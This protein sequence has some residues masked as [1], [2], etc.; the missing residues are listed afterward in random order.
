MTA[1][2]ALMQLNSVPPLY[3][4]SKYHAAHLHAAVLLCV[5]CIRHRSDFGA[6]VLCDPRYS[7]STETTASLSKW[8]RSSVRQC[9]SVEVSLPLVEAFFRQH[10]PQEDRRHAVQPEASACADSTLAGGNGDAGCCAG[11]SGGT[12]DCGEGRGGLEYKPE[13]AAEGSPEPGPVQ[14]SLSQVCIC[15]GCCTPESCWE[16]VAELPKNAYAETLNAH[17]SPLS[18]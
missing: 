5:R 16:R 13:A 10:Q 15:W 14:Q 6:I 3:Q 9:R 17:V 8:V 4:Y 11:G 2:N 18:C 7:S 12:G 1:V